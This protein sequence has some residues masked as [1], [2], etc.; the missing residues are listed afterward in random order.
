MWFLPLN[1]I[2]KCPMPPE[3]STRKALK[4]PKKGKIQ[5]AIERFKKAI[6]IHTNYLMA[7]NNLGVQYLRLGQWPESGGAI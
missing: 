2:S 5:D 3:R 7:R 4:R 1:S 6:A